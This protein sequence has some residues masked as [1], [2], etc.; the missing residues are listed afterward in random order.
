MGSY[1]WAFMEGCPCLTIVAVLFVLRVIIG[2]MACLLD[3]IGGRD[4]VPGGGQAGG[5]GGQ[6]GGAAV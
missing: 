2:L 4:V 5:G 6:A 3:C 1:D